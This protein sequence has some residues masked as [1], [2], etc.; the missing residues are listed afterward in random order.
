MASTL[1]TREKL[2]G[3]ALFEAFPDNPGDPG[4]TGVKHLRASLEEVM[5]RREAHTMAV[6]KYDIRRPE[7]E[8]G[9]F[10]V[11]YWSPVNVPVLGPGGKLT[12]IIHRVQNVTDYVTLQQRQAEGQQERH[13]SGCVLEGT[14][15][16]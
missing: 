4:A 11:R 9:G 3:R 1:T 10:E 13:H 12:H 16:W 15:P 7:S 6:Q 8:G 2:V 14:E 5:R